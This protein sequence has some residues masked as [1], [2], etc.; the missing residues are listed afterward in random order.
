MSRK[1]ALAC[2]L[3]LSALY[4]VAELV[5]GRFVVT[6]DVFFKAAGR[7]WA[8][9]GR[10][11]APE[12]KGYFDGVLVPPTTEV[13][14]AYPPLYSFLF[15]IYTKAVGFGPRS[16]MLYDVMI[17]LLLVWCGALVARLVFGVPWG[18][19]VLCGALL[20]PLG[21]AGRPDELGIV[22]ALGAAL[23]LRSEVPLR[24]GIP[25]GGALL[26]LCCATSPGACLFLGSLAGWEVTV[27]EPSNFGKLRN[28]AI[29]AFIAIV[30]LAV[31]VAPILVAHPLA[32]RQLVT[33]G[34]S[35][36]V[37]GN[38]NSGGY[39]NSGKSFVRL[40]IESL[41]YGYDK[42][43]LIAGGMMFAVLCWLLDRKRGSTPYFRFILVVLSLLLLMVSMPGKYFYLWF[44]GTWLLIA[45]VALGWRVSRSLTPS[46]RYP[47]FAL[48][49]LIWL[50]ASIP[51]FRWK[52]IYWTLPPDQ[53]LT[54]NMNRVRA[55]VP[56]G[57]GV[58]TTEYWWALAGRNPVYDTLF[59]DPNADSFDYVA[60]AGNGSGTPGTPQPPG[61]AIGESQWQ[62]IHDHLPS[63]P[64]SL[65]G[66]RLSRSGYGFGPYILKKNN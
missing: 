63:K 36:T 7:N 51:F 62:N 58:L 41:H 53:T 49:I 3:A 48:G 21:T 61:V 47:F 45:C 66:V 57:A 37:L 12:L 46:R 55:E 27:R 17:H 14:F 39:H 29:T 65:F 26:G 1:T 2:L 33:T 44:S 11:A 40:W 22:F 60:L 56:V 9:T 34:A 25:I 42:A 59:S 38:A 43:F 8:S 30:V 35:Q 10:F 54:F 32:Y 64:P 20:L 31:C 6:D 18:V 4:C 13:F 5:P 15:G 23:A 24:V 19:S 52:A 16:C 50:I 28:F